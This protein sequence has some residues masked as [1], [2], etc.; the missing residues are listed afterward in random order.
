MIQLATAP[1]ASATSYRPA[2][3]DGKGSTFAAPRGRTARAWPFPSRYAAQATQ[4]Q[5]QKPT[6]NDSGS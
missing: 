5:S 3:N 2:P 4:P 6:A 1:N